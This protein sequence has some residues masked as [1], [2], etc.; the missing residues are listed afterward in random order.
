M[1]YILITFEPYA[2]KI[3]IDEVLQVLREY[4]PEI[5]WEF[6]KEGKY[7]IKLNTNK[8]IYDVAQII[9]KIEYVSHISEIVHIT[10][11]RNPEKIASYLR[12]LL[13]DLIKC[14]GQGTFKV[15]V[16]R[17]DKSYPITS[18]ELG[19]LLAQKLID[20]ANPDL[21]NPRYILYVE[22]RDKCILI[23][24]SINDVFWKGKKAIPMEFISRIVGIVEKPQMMY[25][26]MDLIQLSHAL[27]LEIRILGTDE[28]QLLVE[29]ALKKLALTQDVVKVKVYKSIDEIFQGIDIPITL[30]QY[31]VKNEED[32]IELAKNIFNSGK[33]IGFVLGNEYE[34]VSL[35]LRRRC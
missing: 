1:K 13:Q 35:E 6:S 29:K 15:I 34:D 14:W 5:I 33:V 22:V 24:Y 10:S 18:I 31:A 9:R 3:G 25:E 30:S 12:Q 28:T 19:K 8:N 17:V 21:E 23:G 2:K 16:K 27:G 7:V 32:L 11:D 20:I 26:V 4:N